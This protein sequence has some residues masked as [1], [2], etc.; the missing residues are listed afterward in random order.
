M[1]AM[2]EVTGRSRAWGLWVALALSLTLNVFVLGGLGW[3]WMTRPLAPPGVAQRF[4]AIGRSLELT[5]D[6]RDAL[7]QF[8]IT[9]R[10]LARSMREANAP[11]I[12]QIWQEMGNPQPDGTK[13][14][15]LSDQVLENR[16]AFQHK[17]SQNL[18]AFLA[19][20]TPEQRQRF[21]DRAMQPP[22]HHR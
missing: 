6:Q 20:L 17:M 12:H 2:A 14:Q 16:R 22:E 13:I 7:R 10:D 18:I 21:V 9:A 1:S 4:I 5:G 11:L 19:V 8:G 15:G 3:S